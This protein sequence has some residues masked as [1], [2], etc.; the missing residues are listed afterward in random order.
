MIPGIVRFITDDRIP[1]G[2]IIALDPGVGMDESPNLE[3]MLE[4]LQKEQARQRQREVAR[5]GDYPLGPMRRSSG[6]LGGPP[7][8]SGKSTLD[9]SLYPQDFG[10]GPFMSNQLYKLE[11]KAGDTVQVTTQLGGNPREATFVRFGAGDD[12]YT[13]L[14][15][16]GGNTLAY[17]K[18]D[19]IVSIFRPLTEAELKLINDDQQEKA[20]IKYDLYGATRS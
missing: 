15:W 8:Y 18:T 5:R 10:G 9:F 20:E 3:T 4:L 19:S 12:K 13:A 1:D 7:P 17:V 11:I 2:M 6:W 14:V 16:K